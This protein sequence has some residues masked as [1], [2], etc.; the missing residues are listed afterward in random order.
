MTQSIRER[1]RAAV[2]RSP[3][4][5]VV[6]TDNLADAQREAD[7]FIRGGLE[8]I[9]VTFSVPG[10]TDMVRELISQRPDDANYLVGMGTVTTHSRAVDAVAAGAEFI[11]SPNT[12]A[13]VAA[14]AND[15]DTCL[16]YTS[17]SPRDS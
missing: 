14:V 13:H 9:E 5:A 17:P 15:A 8:L 6:R 11:V 12:S 1:T 4:F 7:L 3:I 16:L 10:A 2:Q